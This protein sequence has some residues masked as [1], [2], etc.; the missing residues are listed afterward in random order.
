[1]HN[2]LIWSCVHD[3][4]QTILTSGQN[5]K[6][7]RSSEELLKNFW[8]TSG[9]LLENFFRT[10]GE[11]LESFWGTSG[12]LWFSSFC[13][14]HHCYGLAAN[15]GLVAR[16]K[17]RQAMFGTPFLVRSSCCGGEQCD[18]KEGCSVAQVATESRCRLSPVR[19]DPMVWAACVQVCG[20]S[21]QCIHTCCFVA[22]LSPKD[23][24]RVGGGG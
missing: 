5:E 3:T 8:R 16:V 7:W 10:S 18:L 23:F 20:Y 9:E 1:M 24:G 22:R 2:V 14:S 21:S 4:I 15:R 17:L 19:D 11:L 13:C 6:F 12:E